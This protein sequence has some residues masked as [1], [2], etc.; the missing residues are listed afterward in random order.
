MAA[1]HALG[2]RRGARAGI[3]VSLALVVGLVGGCSAGGSSSD[4][5][6]V[7]SLPAPADTSLEGQT[8]VVDA[9]DGTEAGS[10]TGT[11]VSPQVV[12]TGSA[13]LSTSDPGGSMTQLGD[14]VASLGGTT[15]QTAVSGQGSSQS[16]WATYRIPAASYQDV[17]DSL[18]TYGQVSDL[19]TT[20]EDVGAQ[21]VDVEARIDALQTSVTTL[22]DLM[23]KATST[24][25]LLEAESQLSTRQAELDSLEAQRT[26][27]SDQVSMSTLTVSFTSEPVR[28]EASGSVWRQSWDAFV[29]GMEGLLVA[30]IWVAPWLILVVPLVALLWWVVARRRSRHTRS[31]A[32]AAPS[33]ETVPDEGGGTTV[34]RVQETEP[35]SDPVS[36]QE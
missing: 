12:V 26:W 30:L 4:A 13:T 36:S 27:L 35:T 21:V 23:E 10:S 6:S 11:Q 17:L 16:A 18:T 33:P 14:A 34:S 20:T 24:A 29:S 7:G 22:T 25:D 2:R 8:A 1:R 15:A 31:G 5:S 3:W 19:S 28:G 32:A 9:S